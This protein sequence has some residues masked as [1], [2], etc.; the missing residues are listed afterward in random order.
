MSLQPFFSISPLNPTAYTYDAANPGNPYANAYLTTFGVYTHASYSLASQHAN[1]QL[2]LARDPVPDSNQAISNY[3]DDVF[4]RSAVFAQFRGTNVSTVNQYLLVF[5]L[6]RVFGSPIAQ[7]F[8][9]TQFLRAETLT[10]SPYDDVA[11]LLDVPGNSSYVYPIVRLAATGSGTYHG[12]YFM[13]MDCYL[14]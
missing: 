10:A 14:L 6:A 11:I 1:D 3:N 12:F 7:F 4:R 9:G 2:L 8:A 5:R 13:G